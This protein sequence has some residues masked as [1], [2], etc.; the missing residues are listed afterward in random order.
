MGGIAA[1][2]KSDTADER[3]DFMGCGWVYPSVSLSRE[4]VGSS[5]AEKSSA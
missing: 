4:A 2:G 3:A 1:V 5:M